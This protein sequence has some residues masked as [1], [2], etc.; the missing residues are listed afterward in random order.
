MNTQEDKIKEKLF[1][2]GIKA[3]E[4]H[5]F[6]DAHEYWEDL[7]SDYRLVD[8]K[9]IQGLI[10]LAVGYFHITNLNR[11]GAIGLFNKCI[12]KL[13]EYCPEYR[14]IDIDNIINSV[15]SSLD[16]INENEDL[17]KFDWTIVPKLRK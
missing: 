17:T 4:S 7:W 13:R 9:F 3:F 14:G 2:D 8:A 6:Y 15:L 1:L 12:P 11:N 16:Y 10:Q 5:E